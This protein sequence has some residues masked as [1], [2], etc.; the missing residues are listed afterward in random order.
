MQYLVRLIHEEREIEN[1]MLPGLILALLVNY[2]IAYI[3][4]SLYIYRQHITP[5]ISL[6]S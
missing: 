6:Y 3:Y 5:N 2:F 4:T 1:Y